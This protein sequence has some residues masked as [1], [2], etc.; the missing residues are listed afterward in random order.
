MFGTVRGARLKSALITL[1]GAGLLLLWGA[2]CGSLRPVTAHIPVSDA[3][4]MAVLDAIQAKFASQAGTDLDAQNRELAAFM[5]TFREIED[6]GVSDDSCVWGRFTDGRSLIVV[7]HRSSTLRSAELP[8]PSITRASGLPA[9]IRVQLLDTMGSNYA[10]P[11]EAIKGPLRDSGFTVIG[12]GGGGASVD[13]LKSPG[14][15]GILYMDAH[16]GKGKSRTKER[17]YSIWTDTHVTEA[18][19]AAYK[20]DLDA[21]RLVYMTANA[22]GSTVETRYAFTADFVRQYMHLSPNTLVFINACSSYDDTMRQAFLAAGAGIYFGWTQPVDDR[23]AYGAAIFLFDR[24]LGINAVEPTD[25]PTRPP[26]TMA[27]VVDAMAGTTY[28]VTHLPFD[29]SEGVWGPKSD[30]FLKGDTGSGDLTVITP[31]IR[32]IQVD[33][34]EMTATLKGHFGSRRGTVDANGT[35]KAPGDELTV[36]SWTSTEITVEIESD[37]TSVIVRSDGR[38]SNRRLLP[39]ENYVLSGADGGGFGVDDNL[40]VWWNSDLIFEDP[41]GAYAGYR[42]P[43]RIPGKKGDTIRI[44]V[45]DWYGYYAGYSSI[46]LTTPAGDV[47][48][49][50]PGI[51]K[52]TPPG[53]H[54]IVLNKTYVLP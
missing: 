48:L 25:N 4:R 27:E 23:S 21:H 1:L 7:N 50:E 45:Q 34:E 38:S 37:T 42:G 5:R 19:E 53:N 35:R 20:E 41:R 6:S 52:A 14:E 11:T 29:H 15:T 28:A 13:N 22:S 3:R 33:K 44:E 46:Y 12:E 26:M 31:S 16:G 10:H 43:F 47:L 49:L 51:N 17:F 2:G 40:R 54:N 30:A 36:T 8:R 32:S 9:G 39:S 18:N 24:L